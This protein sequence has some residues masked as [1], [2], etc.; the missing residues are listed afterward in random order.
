MKRKSHEDDIQKAVIAHLRLYGV[1]DMLFWHTPNGG[2]RSITQAVKFKALGVVA[3]I[4]DLLILHGGQL[5]AL[6]LKA[7]KGR[8]S[9][10]QLSVMGNL[11]RAGAK[12]EFAFGLD[13]AL[14]ALRDWKLLRLPAEKQEAA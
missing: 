4:P 13:E 5:H 7:P 12:V 9:F 2:K 3:G 14:R 6:E 1:R 10:D 8:V 11:K